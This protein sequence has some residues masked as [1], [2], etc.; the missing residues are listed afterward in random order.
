[1]SGPDVL[2]KPRGSLARSGASSGA[3]RGTPDHPLIGPARSPRVS[4]PRI[5]TT[6]PGCS[7]SLRAAEMTSGNRRVWAETSAPCATT[8]HPRYRSLRP[9]PSWGA[10]TL[11]PRPCGRIDQPRM[12]RAGRP[13]SRGFKRE[14]EPQSENGC[15]C[16]GRPTAPTRR[17]YPR[18][19]RPAKIM[20]RPTYS[21]GLISP[22][23]DSL[24]MRACR[25]ARR[26]TLTSQAP[27]ARARRTSSANSYRG[28]V[29]SK[30]A[31]CAARLS[32]RRNSDDDRRPMPH[33]QLLTAE[34]FMARTGRLASNRSFILM[35]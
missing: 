30:V 33:L 5:P 18:G 23:N 26:R 4:A 14:Q 29:S 19:V 28:Q 8:G 12:P 7:S 31:R 17:P 1:M 3:D 10:R 6:A 22:G 25:L 2:G 21:A 35:A 13:Q 15:C 34:P 16:P 11:Q 27:A 24:E 32:T 9:D 20:G